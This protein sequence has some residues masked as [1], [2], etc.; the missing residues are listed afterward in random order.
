MRNQSIHRREFFRTVGFGMAALAATPRARAADPADRRPP[1]ILFIMVDDLGKEWVSCYGSRSIKTPHIDALAAG[2]IR[3]ENAYSMPQCTPTRISLLTGQYPWRHG[4]INHWDVPR[5]GCGCHFDPGHYV[6]FAR[7][8][9]SAG[10]VTVAAGKWQVND[11]RVQPTA[12]A[13]HG[14]DAHC[15]WTGFETGVRASAER[16][17]N[18]YLHTN[19]GSRGYG[20]DVFGED[21][22]SDFLIDFMKKNVDKPMLMYYPMCLTHG[23]FTDT[24]IERGVEGKLERHK[25]M[26]RYT[27]HILGK[28]VKALD[29]LGLRENTIVFWTTDNGSGG[30]TGDINGRPVKGGK[31]QTTESGVNAPFIVNCPGKVPAGV[32]SDTLTDFTDMLPTFAELGGAELPDGAAVDGH[33]IAKVITGRE[34]DGT[35]NW[36][37]AMGSHPARVNE[38]GRV[39]PQHAYRDRVIRDKRYKLSVGT[40]RKATKLIDLRRDPDEQDNILASADADAQKARQKLEAAAAAFPEKD[41]APKY[42]PTPSQK[43]DTKP[44][45]SR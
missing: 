10:Y 28:L 34:Q 3:F 20:K 30:V 44:G 1:N 40:D 43:W 26:V 23:P 39:V 9:K 2:G 37:M 38:D 8:M 41:A 31:A 11:F 17:W 6:S 24:P 7:V 4:W 18:P 42:D 36:I 14:F 25:A 5:W 33:S 12:M 15:M 13:A 27:D 16:Y 32:V 45:K 35:R 19:D 29:G 21:V 22:F